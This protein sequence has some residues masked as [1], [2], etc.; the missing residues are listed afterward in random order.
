MDYFAKINELTAKKASLIEKAEGMVAENKFGDEL[1]KIKNEIKSTASQIETLTDLAAQSSAGAAP[2]GGVQNQGGNADEKKGEKKSGKYFNSL[3]EQLRAIYNFKKTGQMDERL[4]KVNNDV[5]GVSTGVGADGGFALQEDFA[6][7]ILESA[8]KG[9]EI[10]SRVN[11]YTVGSGSNS[12][13][14]VAVDETDI[15]SSVYGGV[16]MY[17]AA[18]GGTV[19]ASKPKFR[20]VKCDLEKMM[21][22]AYATEEMLSDV[23]FMSSFFG[24]CFTLASTRLLEDAIISGDGEGKPLGIR[25]SGAMIQ[26]PKTADQAAG[27]IT[28]DNILG[29]WQRGHY[30]YRKGM[31]WLAHPD[32]EEQLQRLTLNGESIWLPE[33]GLAESPYQKVLG[34][35]VI[36]TDQCSAIGSAGDIILA[37]MSKYTLVKKG[38]ARQDWSMHV[39][40]LTDQQCFRMVLR[41][42]GRPEVDA[43]L[44]IKNS[45][46]TRSPFVSLAARA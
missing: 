37:D 24:K 12:V 34:R 43:P 30:A 10:L 9:G 7:A 16:Q 29:M 42:N 41:C 32:C 28:G 20:E 4:S 25:N 38:T 3:G 17:W 27:T 11:K 44:T 26:V 22:F 14:W 31:V 45:K 1:E 40:F 39:E 33:G 35:P 18:E 8:A 36:Y 46:L 19:A 23:A 15:S 21:G 6:G 13:R 5:M 2:V